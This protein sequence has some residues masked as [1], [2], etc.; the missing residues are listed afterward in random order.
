MKKFYRV[1]TYL[2]PYWG[3]ASLNV[4]FNLLTIVFSLFSM[5]LLVP[6]LNLLF[7]TET[8]VTQKPEFALNADSLIQILNYYISQIII[9]DGQHKAL[10]YICIIL[11]VAFFLR[12]L[13]RFFAMFYMANVRIGSVKDIRNSIYRKILILPLSF[14]NK[15]RKGDI[16]SRV[17][18]DVQEVEYSIMNY[19]EMI[20][21]DP[22]TILVYI[23]F[24]FSVSPQLTLFVLVLLPITGFLIGQIGKSLRKSSKIGQARMAGMLSIIE[25]TISGLRIIKAFGAI[26]YS[27]TRFKDQNS[28]FSKLMISIYRRRDLSSPLSEFLSSVVIVIVLWF[29]GRLVLGE[30]AVIQ[31]ADFI[32]YII[33]FSQIIPPAKTFAQGFYSIQKGIASAERIFEILDAEE[34]ITEKKDAKAIQSFNQSIKYQDVWFAYDK[35]SILKNINLEIGKGKLIALVGESGGGK[36]TLVDLLPR[37]YDVVDGQILIDGN[38]IRDYKIDDLR[39]LMGIVTQES[40]L[41]NDTVFNNIAFGDTTATHE[42]VIEAAKIA[43]A[44]EFIMRLENGYESYIGDRGMNLS[45]GQRQRLSIAR[46]VLKNPPILILDEATSS[47]DTESERLVQEALAKVMSSRTSVVIAHRLSTIQHADEIIVIVSGQIAERGTHE[48]LLAAKGVYKRLHDMQ[49]FS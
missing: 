39:S 28:L 36:S 49:T 7:G 13:T 21:R 20:I 5:T 2:K 40:I 4:L 24:M 46:A 44:H 32:V 1:L 31:A 17:T 14:Y 42:S 12:N 48:Q 10:V 33:V 41:F 11:I 37:F 26:N 38:D 35:E 16:I 22:I 9:E 15:H 43:N 25:E 45:G 6:F 23:A 18:T 29:G 19:L 34:V 3:Y 8:L 47:L 27:D 30:S